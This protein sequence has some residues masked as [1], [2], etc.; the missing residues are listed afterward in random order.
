MRQQV[1]IKSLKKGSYV[2]IDD[3]PCE[4]SKVS[5]S[6]PGKHG[7]AKIKI[8]AKGVFDGR[9]RNM[10]KPA[11]TNVMTPHIDKKVGQVVSKSGDSVQLMDMSS[12]DTF[13]MPAESI[14]AEEGEEID[15]WVIDG[16]KMIKED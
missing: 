10:T 15:Y 8:Q 5:K 11:G 1:D 3:E 13:Q 7:S 6:S 2:V 4:V 16:K 9:T 14:N 12:Y